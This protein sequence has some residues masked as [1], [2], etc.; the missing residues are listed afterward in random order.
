VTLLPRD[1]GSRR[2]TAAAL[3]LRAAFALPVLL[4]L[5]DG[6]RAEVVS[7]LEAAIAS[8]RRDAEWIAGARPGD[9]GAI[10]EHAHHIKGTSG[11]IG[12]RCLVKISSR[13]EKAA[14]R[15]PARLVPVLLPQLRAAVERLDAEIHAYA[16]APS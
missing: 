2:L 15:A 16:E 11:S 1:A 3:P 7:L 13:I 8:I 6:D 14:T 4:D 10:V 9:L 12:A 5:F